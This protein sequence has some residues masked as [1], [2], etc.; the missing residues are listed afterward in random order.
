VSLGQL[1]LHRWARCCQNKELIHRFLHEDVLN[2]C[3][4]QWVAVVLRRGFEFKKSANLSTAVAQPSICF[5]ELD[6]PPCV[7]IGFCADISS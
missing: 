7:V 3:W 1:K 6:S 2:C 5:S 4:F